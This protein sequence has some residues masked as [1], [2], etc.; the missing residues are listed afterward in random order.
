MTRSTRFQKAICEEMERLG[1]AEYKTRKRK[2]PNEERERERESKRGKGHQLKNS[3]HRLRQRALTDD[4]N[5]SDKTAT[6]YI[7]DG[8]DRLPH[9]YPGKAEGD[10]QMQSSPWN[11][12]H[13]PRIGRPP[14]RASR[15]HTIKFDGKEILAKILPVTW[16]KRK[17]SPPG[18]SGRWSLIAEANV[19][20]LKKMRYKR[21]RILKTRW[22]RVESKIALAEILPE[23]LT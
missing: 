10:E 22:M 1:G 5:R 4:D 15:S 19:V 2:K 14:L 9:S 23:P 20:I 17:P 7:T 8:A 13:G 18:V 12:L 6:E 3:G 16:L 21:S 11:K